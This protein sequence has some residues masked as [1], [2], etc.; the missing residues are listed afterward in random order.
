[1]NTKENTEKVYKEVDKI[2]KGI[3]EAISSMEDF[4]KSSYFY[5][6]GHKNH[7]VPFDNIIQSISKK[8]NLKDFQVLD[9][10]ENSLIL[11]LHTEEESSY[12][13][14]GYDCSFQYHVVTGHIDI[15]FNKSIISL[16]STQSY[17]VEKHISHKVIIDNHTKLILV[18]NY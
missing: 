5:T 16:N 12:S 4:Y 9:L 11:F 3:D 6:V 10:K 18:L 17:Y 1:M 7:P 8:I 14:L 15:D 13:F 2:S